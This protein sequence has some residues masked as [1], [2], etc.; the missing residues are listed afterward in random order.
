MTPLD[1]VLDMKSE[2]I[3]V[4]GT[5]QSDKSK[6]ADVS[7]HMLWSDAQ[8]IREQPELVPSAGTL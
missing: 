6:A 1:A 4:A 7:N 2:S 8:L 3:R 5:H